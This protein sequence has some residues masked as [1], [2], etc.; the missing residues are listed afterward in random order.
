[1]SNTQT[2]QPE[3]Q[4]QPKEEDLQ[5]RIDGFNKELSPLLGKYELGLAAIAKILQ[6]GRVAADPVIISMRGKQD[7][8][9][10]QTKPDAKSEG[11]TNPEA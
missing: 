7:Q 1:M 10:Q 9:K 3:Q 6:D 4:N 8:L 11:I 5:E 2:P